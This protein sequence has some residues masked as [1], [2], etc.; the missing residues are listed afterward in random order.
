MK[1]KKRRKDRFSPRM[2]LLQALTHGPNYGYGLMKQIKERS[3]GAFEIGEGTLYPTLSD[4]E[5]DGLV[6]SYLS[7]PVD[8]RGGLPRKYYELTAEG[9]RQARDDS[10]M[11]LSLFQPTLE[12][13][14]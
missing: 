1:T 2:A 8:G 6:T 14:S 10:K 3:E 5:S 11:I 13:S 7:E 4:M 9:L 12:G